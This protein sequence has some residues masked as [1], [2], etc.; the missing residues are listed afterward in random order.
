MHI[1]AKKGRDYT[2]ECLVKKGANFRIEDKYGVSDYST[3]DRIST[4]D[5]SQS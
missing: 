1:A 5:L 4:P 3:G 2:V